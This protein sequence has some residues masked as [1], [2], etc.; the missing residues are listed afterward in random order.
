MPIIWGVLQRAYL[1]LA[2]FKSPRV[3]R[4]MLKASKPAGMQEA[5]AASVRGDNKDEGG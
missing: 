3:T 1:L 5:K 4:D 2:P